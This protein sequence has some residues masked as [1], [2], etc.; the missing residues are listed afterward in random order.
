MPVPVSVAFSES[1]QL[2]PASANSAH[3]APADLQGCP[4]IG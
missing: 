4:W 2:R 3:L 1:S